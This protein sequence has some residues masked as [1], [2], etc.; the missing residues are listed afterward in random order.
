MEALAHPCKSYLP[1]APHPGDGHVWEPSRQT[2]VGG[3]EQQMAPGPTLLR[4]ESTQLLGRA[5]SKFNGRTVVGDLLVVGEGAPRHG[6][7]L[8][9]DPLLVEVSGP[10]DG[11]HLASHDSPVRGSLVA[12]QLHQSK[13]KLA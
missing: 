7:Q 4:Q 3:G 6:R 13:W 10:L 9:P 1:A 11:G 12:M 5:S 2:G 8:P